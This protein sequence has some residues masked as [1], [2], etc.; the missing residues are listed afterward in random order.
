MQ[1]GKFQN[2]IFFWGG[3]G[4]KCFSICQVTM[5]Y[6][7]EDLSTIVIFGKMFI[8]RVGELLTVLVVYYL[9]SY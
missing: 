9:F 1:L 8:V 3:E 5:R 4:P 7:F 6:H 2:R